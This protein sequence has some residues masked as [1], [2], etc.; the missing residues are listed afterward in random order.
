MCSQVVPPPT[1]VPAASRSS[2]GLPETTVIALNV[3]IIAAV[4][5]ADRTPAETRISAPGS[6]AS[7]RS[8]LATSSLSKDSRP[9]SFMSDAA[10]N[11]MFF[12]TDPCGRHAQRAKTSAGCIKEAVQTASMAAVFD[13]TRTQGCHECLQVEVANPQRS[14]CHC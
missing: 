9:G 5:I 1:P 6:R 4:I 7:A 2:A 14:D 10:G 11:I 3:N 8:K 12:V 13:G